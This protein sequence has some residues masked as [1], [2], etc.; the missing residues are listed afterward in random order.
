VLNK[1]HKEALFK[2]LAINLIILFIHNIKAAFIY[3]K[4]VT[5]FTLNVQRAFDAILKRQLLKHIIKQDWPFF[6]L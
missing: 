3:S 5:I 1:Q 6:L 4:K 2:Q